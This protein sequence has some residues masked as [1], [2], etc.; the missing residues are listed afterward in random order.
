MPAA[1]AAAGVHSAASSADAV[2]TLRQRNND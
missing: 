2:L 1:A